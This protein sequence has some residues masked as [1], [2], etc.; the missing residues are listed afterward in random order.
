MNKS[1]GNE[2]RLSKAYI[3]LLFSRMDGAVSQIGE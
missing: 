3:E 1:P 2:Q